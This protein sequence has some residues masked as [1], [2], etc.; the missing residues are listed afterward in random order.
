MWEFGIRNY[1][2]ES[3]VEVCSLE[4]LLVN[5][6]IHIVTLLDVIMWCVLGTDACVC[7]I[8]C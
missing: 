2:L 1:L 8:T 6:T 3:V 5:D 7:V 4:V